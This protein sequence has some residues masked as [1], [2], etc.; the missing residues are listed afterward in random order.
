MQEMGPI[1]RDP[2]DSRCR[3]LCHLFLRAHP[4][5]S[6]EASRALLIFGCCDRH[7]VDDSRTSIVSDFATC[8]G[9][10]ILVSGPAFRH[11]AI[12]KFDVDIGKH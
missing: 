3:E 10:F 1:F 9:D 12:R 11:T 8:S 2:M 7:R 5:R 6:H 4:Q